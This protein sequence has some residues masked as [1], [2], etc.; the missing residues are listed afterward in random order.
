M[1]QYDP[2]TASEEA[3]QEGLTRLAPSPQAV[4]PDQRATVAWLREAAEDGVAAA[5]FKLGLCFGNGIG[6][7]RNEAAAR[8]WYLR[9]AAQG[10]PAAR[11]RL[12]R[13]PENA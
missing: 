10:H 13:L 9:A 5:Q 3:A 8:G 7:E 12:E 2:L 6:V 4:E 11:L 1:P